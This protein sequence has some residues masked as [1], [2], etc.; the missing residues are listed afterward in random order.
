MIRIGSCFTG[1]GAWEKGFEYMGIETELKFYCENDKYAIKSYVSMFEDAKNKNLGDI[2]KID[3]TKIEDIDIFAYS[4]PCQAFSVAGKQLGYEDKRGVLFF[5]A[6]EIIKNKKPKIC[7]M[8][9]VKGLTGKKF[10]SEFE[11]MLQSL[12]N[13]GYNNYWKVLNTRNYGLPQNRERL[14]VIS[15]RKDIDNGLFSFPEPLD[16]GLRLK[17]MLDKEV[18]E[19]YYIKKEWHYT[20]EGELKHDNNEIA[21]VNGVKFK[22]LRT[23]SDVEKICRCLDTMGGGQREPKVIRNGKLCKV[24]PKECWRLQGFKDEDFEKASKVNSNSQLYKQSGNS[25]S[26]NVLIELYKELFKVVKFDKDVK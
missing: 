14:F 21:Q 22:A 12:E 11:E 18:E 17:D 6:F 4:P 23:I 24:T 2:T 20:E 3:V 25:I 1:I 19:K 26:I 9:N 8:E 10:N 5:D 13:E 15:I 16:S 7:M